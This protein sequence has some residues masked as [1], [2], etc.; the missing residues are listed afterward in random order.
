M[1][2]TMITAAITI[3]MVVRLA[4]VEATGTTSTSR[5]TPVAGEVTR[6]SEPSAPLPSRC[7]PSAS[8]ESVD[9]DRAR[10]HDPAGCAADGAHHPAPPAGGRRVPALLE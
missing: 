10:H 6:R 1:M 4:V 9:D 3:H 2:P 8:L 7:S 5:R